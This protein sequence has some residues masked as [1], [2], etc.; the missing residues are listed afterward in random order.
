MVE[1]GSELL[2]LDN[3]RFD[4]DTSAIVELGS[5]LQRGVGTEEEGEFPVGT[6]YRV[7]AMTTVPGAVYAE[8]GS[9]RGRSLLSGHLT[10]GRA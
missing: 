3:V 1:N 8:L 2:G 4:Q 10:V 9:Y 6:L 5:G 7:T